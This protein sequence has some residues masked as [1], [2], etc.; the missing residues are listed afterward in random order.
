MSFP[1]KD[2]AYSTTYKGRTFF[3]DREKCRKEFLYDPAKFA[4]EPRDEP[5]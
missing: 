4:G 3:F 1:V 5:A 2:A